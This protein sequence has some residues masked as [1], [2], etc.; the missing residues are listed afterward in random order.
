MIRARHLVAVSRACFRPSSPATLVGTSV[1]V[2]YLVW[3]S[4]SEIDAIGA[5]AHVHLCVTFVAGG[6]WVG[7]CLGRAANWSGSAFTRA[8]APTL[9]LAAALAATSVLGINVV[10]GYI[11]GMDPWSL[12]ALGSFATAVG[13]ALGRARPAATFYLFLVLGI[14]VPIGPVIG[15]L[16]PLP[17]RGT[18]GA[19]LLVAAPVAATALLAWFASRLQVPTVSSKSLRPT[20]MTAARVLPSLLSEPTLPRVAIWSGLM[21][22]GCTLAHRHAGL[23]WRDGTLIAVI[24]AMCALLGVTAT[25]VSLSRGPLPGAA[26][27]LLWGAARDR[28]SAGRRVLSRIFADHLFAAGVFTAVT[29]ALGSGWHLVE[30]MLVALA[31]CHAYL[32]AASPN[33]WLLSN[34]FSV[35][36]STPAVGAIAW[37][38]WT[39]FPW[40]L[41]TALAAF[42]LSGSAA[43]YLGGLG[44]GRVNLDFPPPPAPAS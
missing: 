10:A 4:A 38:A 29:V 12:T 2:A 15:P 14:L 31:A 41:P 33:R 5:T 23:E 16:L 44:M 3:L 6:A 20:S 32:A 35:L 39:P 42:L 17:I 40:A 13:L 28:R 18:T 7:A 24:G 21:A 26:W 19:M 30:M 34:P 1:Y 37:A 36:V 22:A 8:F 9:V 25:S 11:A 27:L 43:V